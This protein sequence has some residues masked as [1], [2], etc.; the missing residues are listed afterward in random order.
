MRILVTGS[1]GLLGKSLCPMLDNE[2]WQYWAC[3]SKIFDITNTKMVNEIMNKISLDFIIHLAGYTNID[4]AEDNP[5]LAFNV[6]QLGTR[7][8]A[9]IAKKHNIPILYVSTDNVFDG[10]SETPY[11]PTD[12]T[13]PINTYGKSKLAGEKEI[14]KATKK[15]YILR[16]S[17]LYGAGGY[18]DAMLTFSNFRKEISVVND[19]IGCPTWTDDIS[20]K[21]VEIIKEN[22]PYGI[23][24][25]SSSGSASWAD[26]TKKIFE[27]KKRNVE[28]LSIDK[29]DFP[30]PAL[31]P[32]YCVLDSENALPNW[33][34][35]LEEYLTNKN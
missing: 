3:N 20:R 13:N 2:G 10:T 1:S 19:Q 7:N 31:R 34:N 6:N 23:Y 29:S 28:V 18:V 35:S 11:K 24:H 32:K 8:I 25:V 4:Q 33:E 5:E 30:R 27:I 26:F 22:K 15:H 16:T 14:I 17:W 9:H 21:I 12:A